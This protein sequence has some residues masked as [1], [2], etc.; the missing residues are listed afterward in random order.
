M[1]VSTGI[2]GITAKIEPITARIE[3]VVRC[4]WQTEPMTTTQRAASDDPTA[5][6][7]QGRWALVTGASRGIGRE[8]A[9]AL[10]DAGVNVVLHSSEL[11]GTSDLV[12]KV[13]ERGIEAAGIAVDLA[14]PTQVR[15]VAE[16]IAERFDIDFLFNNA[17]VNIAPQALNQPHGADAWA[18]TYLVNVVAPA[19]LIT[20][21]LPGMIDRGF[22]RIVNTT[23]GILDQP[24]SYAA[25][26]GAL[27]KLTSDYPA[28]LVGTGVTMNVLDPGWIKT[29][30]GGAD[31]EHELHTVIPG[32]IVGA[33]LP[34]EVTGMWINAQDFRGMSLAAAI[35]AAPEKLLKISVTQ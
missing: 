14:E 31:A 19:T 29:D 11:S 17:G 2:Q 6:C 28:T 27:N 35:A 5:V 23:S 22:G 12:E 24:C 18:K 33:F 21:I 25:S 13:R 4:A 9:L 34:D 8:M 26:K 15:A 16:D 10:A 3:Y 1:W 30:L 20:A 7:A 32:A